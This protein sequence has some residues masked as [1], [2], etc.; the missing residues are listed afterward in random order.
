MIQQNLISSLDFD[1]YI[2]IGQNPN[3]I[4]LDLD[5]YITNVIYDYFADNPKFYFKKTYFL[6]FE[7]EKID[8]K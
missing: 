1:L 4:K 3:S 6:P 8:L 2:S 5:N 7:N